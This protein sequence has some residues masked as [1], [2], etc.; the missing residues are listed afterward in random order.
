MVNGAP[1]QAKK[2][3]FRNPTEFFEAYSNIFGDIQDFSIYFRLFSMTFCA[4]DI[5]NFKKKER[6]LPA[7]PFFRNFQKQDT[8][9][10]A[11]YEKN[12]AN[13]NL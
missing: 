1:F 2:I 4:L 13:N 7:N 9:F 5:K 11:L 12:R 6:S 8:Y 10:L 3:I